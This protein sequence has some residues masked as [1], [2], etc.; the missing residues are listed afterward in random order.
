MGYRSTIGTG[1]TV[2]VIVPA[3]E[4]TVLICLVFSDR[5]LNSAADLV[6]YTARSLLG[7]AV[8]VFTTGAGL[9]A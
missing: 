7:V 1:G 4:A 2:V 9:T 8:N 6:A 5:G 3:V